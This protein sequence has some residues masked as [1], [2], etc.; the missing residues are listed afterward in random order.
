[1]NRRGFSLMELVIVIAISGVLAFVSYPA[2]SRIGGFGLKAAGRG[3]A[4]DLEF[5]KNRAISTHTVC[6]ASFDATGDAYTLFTGTP[7]TPLQH[8]LRPGQSYVV[9]LAGQRVDLVSASFGGGAEVRF[10]ALGQPLDSAN[11]PYTAQGRVILARGADRDT[12]R[13][14]AFTGGVR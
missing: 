7:A 6:G 3:L 9:R 2:L 12:V 1:M 5:A 14:D 10:D 4:A 11:Q 8:P 13:V